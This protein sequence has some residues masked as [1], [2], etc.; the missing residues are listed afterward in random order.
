MIILKHLSELERWNPKGIACTIGNFDG[1][2]KA[3]QAIIKKVKAKAKKKKIPSLVITFDYRINKEKK[4]RITSLTHKMILLERCGIDACY[5][6]KLDNRFGKIS[7]Q[8]FL[9]KILFKKFH[10]SYLHVGYNFHFGN[11]R[12]G[13]P[14]MIKEWA[15]KCNV[16]CVI[17][18]SISANKLAI[19]STRIRQLIKDGHL[20][21]AKE[22]LGRP[23]SIFSSVVKGA[24]RGTV[25]GVPTANLDIHSEILP[26]RGVYAVDVSF[27]NTKQKRTSKGMFF[28]EKAD[29][30]IYRSVLN[31]G[32]C[33]TFGPGTPM[34]AEVHIPHFSKNI[35]KAL[36]EVHFLKRL[37]SEQTFKSKDG[38]LRQ[39][40]KDINNSENV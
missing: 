28:C 15:D 19:S 7:A 36:L 22:L 18:D 40:M 30:K 2:H 24:G 3:H 10:L 34:H 23:Y 11:K 32:Y 39:I 16:N 26:P 1:V 21:R 9:K 5:V 8:N 35:R 29:K 33:P 25:I 12:E 31:I 13:T 20:E 38:L 17:E 37:R 4:P 6:F 14:L 27:I